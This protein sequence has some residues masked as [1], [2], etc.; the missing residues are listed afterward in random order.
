MCFVG[1]E[2]HGQMED[3]EDPEWLDV[4]VEQLKD[5]K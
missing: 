1:P 5:P 2:I 4:D 3:E